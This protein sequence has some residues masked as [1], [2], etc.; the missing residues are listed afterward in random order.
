MLPQIEVDWSAP[1]GYQ[2]A[3]GAGFHGA[4]PPIAFAVS[5][6]NLLLNGMSATWT[7]QPK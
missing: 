6:P 3:A 1:L 4:A 2:L 5:A 7:L